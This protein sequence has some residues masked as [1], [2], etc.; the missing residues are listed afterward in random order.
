MKK[1][2]QLKIAEWT[3]LAP[4]SVFCFVYPFAMVLLSFDWMPFGM[5]WMSSLLLATL[6]LTAGSWLWLN[7]GTKGLGVG[8]AIFILGVALEY[9]G[10]NSGVPFGRYRY[11]GVL[12]PN[13][14][15]GVP[16]AIGFAW[17]L[18]VVGGLF[19]ANWVL[20]RFW[21]TA[22]QEGT[23]YRA[24]T[25]VAG[26]ALAVGLDLLLEPVA[27]HVKGYWEWLEEGEGYYGVPWSNFVAWFVAA[28]AMGWL[29]GAVL[30]HGR[31][32][33]WR[34]VPVALY[35][36][37]VLL[38]GVVNVAHGYWAPGVIG[39]ILLIILYVGKRLR[40]SSSALP[41]GFA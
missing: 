14:P 39:L 23:I 15:G 19:T 7:F 33:K 36:M 17:L 31:L 16:I 25:Y 29:V 26:A 35:G 30:G 32:L 38:F 18:I 6:G 21:G 10:V 8:L 3:V 24:P 1:I 4:F 12:V 9:I 5:E 28:L 34:W 11:T 27:F 37:N 22:N 40:Y 41:G 2:G 13:L 20:E